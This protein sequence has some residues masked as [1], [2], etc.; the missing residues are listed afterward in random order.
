[1]SL[2]QTYN[3]LLSK[4]A[5]YLDAAQAAMDNNNQSDYQSAMDNATALNTQIDDVKALMDEQDRYAAF[6]APTL[7]TNERDMTE[8]GELLAAGKA[9]KFN[10][11]EVLRDAGMGRTNATT[12]ATGSLVQPQ[13][14]GSTIRDGFASQVSS[15]I[16]QVQTIDLTGMTAYEEPYV[17]SEQA[18]QTGKVTELAGSARTASDPTFAKARINPYEVNVTSFVDRNLSRLNP[19]DYAAKIQEMALRAL[20]RK[21]NQLVMLGDGQATSDMYGIT[22]AI[23]TDGKA[24]YSSVKLGSA[25]SVD[26]LDKLVFGYGGD[27]EVGANARLYLTKA[28]L[29]AFGALRGANEKHRLYNITP[30][31]DNA[32]TGI[33]TDGG[34]IVPYTIVSSLGAGSLAYGD[35]YNYLLGLFGDFVIRVDESVKAVERMHTILGDVTL[36]GNLVIDKGFVVGTLGS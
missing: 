26:T 22:T 5:N 24:I 16:D 12:L 14:A 13:G 3:D 21:A 23:N 19:A 32:N 31:A 35:P 28:N 18:A 8:M 4:R 27:E 7:G 20:R 1:M 11:A 9:V 2:R 25:I 17:V 6:N 34:L 36:G 15:L 10:V 33:I 30:D 29:Q